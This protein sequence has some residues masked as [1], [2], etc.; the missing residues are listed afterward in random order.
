MFVCILMLSGC[1]VDLYSGLSQEDVNQMMV[2]LTNADI[3][4]DKSVAK[5]GSL[6]LAVDKR[7]FVR[8][9][10]LLRQHGYPR[11]TYQSVNDIFP[12]GQLV[13]SPTQ[14]RVKINYL[15]E[16]SLE[17]MLSDIDGVISARVSVALSSSDPGEETVPASASVFIKYSSDVN[18]EGF[19]TQIK[20]LVHNSVPELNYDAISVVLQPAQNLLP[21]VSDTASSADNQPFWMQEDKLP[22]Y[23]AL[24]IAWL[25][26]IIAVII[27]MVRRRRKNMLQAS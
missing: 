20:S 3:D 23:G 14:E 17:K 19:V 5:D 10:E 2:V 6:S 4:S 12:S 26:A 11:K 25:V 9:V 18:M 7:D 13:T 27:G 1:K 21:A 8:S 24:G 15:K 16:Q 22:V